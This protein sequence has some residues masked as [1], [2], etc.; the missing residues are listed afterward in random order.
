[1][2]LALLAS[3]LNKSLNQ[4]SDISRSAVQR[5]EPGDQPKHKPQGAPTFVK[6]SQLSVANGSQRTSGL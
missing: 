2:V 1:M 6:L 4:A 5:H 3:A